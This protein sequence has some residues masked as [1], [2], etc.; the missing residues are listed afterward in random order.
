MFDREIRF[1]E[2]VYMES[3]FDVAV[4]IKELSDLIHLYKLC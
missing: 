4:K 1:L 2:S 3:E